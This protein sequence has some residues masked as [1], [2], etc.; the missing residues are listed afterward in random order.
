MN[1][2]LVTPIQESDIASLTVGQRITISGYIYAGRDAVLPKITELI[3]QNRLQEYNLNLRGGVVFHTAVSDAGVGP[4]TSN[5]LEIEGSIPLLSSAG[6]KIHM[7][8]G[9]MSKETIDVLKMY[10][11]IYVVTP[12][13]TA[14]LTNC[15]LEK[16]V[17]A[18]PELTMEAFYRLKVVNVPAMVAIAHGKSIFNRE[19]R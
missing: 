17:A 6:I 18:F 5:K 8:K 12:P 4:T 11:S 19:E 15:V 1:I 3:E 9:E 10:H 16:Q 13:V 7:G 2:E 14:L